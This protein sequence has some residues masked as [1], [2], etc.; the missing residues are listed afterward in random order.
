LSEWLRK[1]I[2]STDSIDRLPTVGGFDPVPWL[3]TLENAGD[4]FADA[5][6]EIAVRVSATVPEDS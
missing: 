5:S 1:A 4:V 2:A 6:G 3:V